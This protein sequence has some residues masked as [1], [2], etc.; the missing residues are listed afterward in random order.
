MSDLQASWRSPSNIAL[1]KYW[2]K[3]DNQLPAN[4]SLSFTLSESYTQTTVSLSA[5]GTNESFPFD[6][7]LDGEPKPEFKG[8]IQTFLERI[9]QDLNW[10]KGYRLKIE[11]HNSFPHSSGIASSA[12]GLS[13]LALC[14]LSLQEKVT[15]QAVPDFFQKASTWARLGSGSASRSVYGPLGLWGQFA[16]VP[17]SANEHAIPYEGE[18]HSVFQNF[19]DYIL[20]V[21]KGEKSVSSSAGHG[22]MNGHP[23]AE[24]RFLQAHENL[25]RLTRHLKTGDL[26]SFGQL[27]ES[28]ALTLHAMM[29]TSNPYY[30][31]M[32]PNTLEIIQRL[33]QF[34]ADS[35]IPAYFTL[36]AGANV[37]LLFPG[38]YEQAVKEWV[39]REIKGL[40]KSGDYIC[41][42]IGPGPVKLWHMKANPF[43]Y[44]KILLFGEYGIINDA[45]GLSIPYN[46]YQGAFKQTQALEGFSEKSNK[47]LQRFYQH[48]NTL[49]ASGEAKAEL[50]LAA[51]KKDIE[52]GYYFDSSIPEG[53]GVGSSG[54]LCAAI[55][56][57]YAL[58]RIDPEEDITKEN[59]L[60]LKEIL[61]Q[62]ESFFHGKSSGLDP[63][64][65]YLKLPVLINS[66]NELGPV[67]LPESGEGKGAIFLLNSGQPGETEPMV[68]IFMEKMKHEG[69][70]KVMKE[71][72]TKYNDACIQAFLKGDTAPL[73]SNLKKLSQLVFENFTPMIPHNIKEL[74]KKGMDTN[75]YYLKLCGSGGGG[76]VL[77]FT[78]DYAKAE[79]ILKGHQTELIYRF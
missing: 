8:K 47:S 32:K 75:A 13:A 28:E 67:N 12:S 63:L 54:A 7:Y 19:C 26:E 29:M 16:E 59:I 78:L 64:I 55:Y 27:V 68:N 35:K 77:G 74:W 34:R 53:Y 30:L 52:A 50:D 5:D 11:T 60:R 41:D 31:L 48:L 22:L 3:Y 9:A 36:D 1:V 4:P 58:Q 70:R 45:K 2:G 72:F 66:K 25:S 73:F 17:Q 39:K 46:Y 79:K 14:L 6:L 21:E 44:A 62:M 76:F 65:C 49:Q 56:D 40:L 15:G 71:K 42:R 37:H 24:R 61:G 20:L 23:Y 57:R 38:N 69:F 18:V 43:Y 10:L 51:F 33:W